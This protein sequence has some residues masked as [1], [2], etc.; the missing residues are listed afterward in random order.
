MR[1]LFFK[2]IA[3]LSLIQGMDAKAASCEDPN[4]TFVCAVEFEFSSE[5]YAGIRMQECLNGPI[6]KCGETG[7][8]TESGGHFESS[9]RLRGGMEGLEVDYYH[10]NQGIK[11]PGS[12]SEEEFDLWLRFGY[13]HHRD[14][15][16]KVREVYL[17]LGHPDASK[18]SES[19]FKFIDGRGIV[20]TELLPKE[21]IIHVMS[22]PQ[23]V[24][25]SG[26]YPDQVLRQV[27]VRCDYRKLK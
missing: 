1:H 10:I 9:M 20:G 14:T 24:T 23:G 16:S 4:G 22:N 25:V 2:T 7:V 11:I 18:Q 21:A 27:E 5:I 8:W 15:K 26:K 3:I 19:S 13:T 17:G 12:Q 6:R